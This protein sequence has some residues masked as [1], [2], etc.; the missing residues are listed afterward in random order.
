[1]VEH[2]RRLREKEPRRVEPSN[3]RV[4]VWRRSPPGPRGEELGIWADVGARC[5]T[6]ARFPVVP[7]R[8]LSL[9]RHTNTEI[10]CKNKSKKKK[11]C[12][13]K[14]KTSEIALENKTTLFICEEKG[15]EG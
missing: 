4:V 2:T 1:M 11:K 6:R 9:H 8:D 7:P 10:K 12:E 14:R 5:E 13:H 15:K 3:K